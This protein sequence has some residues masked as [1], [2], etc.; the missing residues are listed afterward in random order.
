[1]DN[2]GRGLGF[3]WQHL[4]FEELLYEESVTSQLNERTS[5]ATSGLK[6]CCIANVGSALQVYQVLTSLPTS[7]TSQAVLYSLVVLVFDSST[8]KAARSGSLAEVRERA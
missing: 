7:M 4:T 8:R 5:F 1:M 2:A 6:K 3:L